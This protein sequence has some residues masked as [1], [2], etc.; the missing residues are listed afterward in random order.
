[1]AKPWC[2]AVRTSLDLA[3]VAAGLYLDERE[4]LELFANIRVTT[5]LAA[6]WAERVMPVPPQHDGDVI[7]AFNKS[8]IR[9]QTSRRIGARRS[10]SVAELIRDARKVERYIVVDARWFPELTFYPMT[11]RVIV[12]Q[13][14]DGKLTMS[15]VAPEDFDTWARRSFD[16]H[17]QTVDWN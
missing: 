4:A 13:A 8:A 5:W 2:H 12:K 6:V 1:M 7:R 10:C 3:H 15:G 14:I 11:A 9:F 16:L 17:I